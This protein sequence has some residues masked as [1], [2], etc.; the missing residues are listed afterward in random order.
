MRIRL[1]FVSNSS[2]A[3]FLVSLEEFD[4]VIELAGYYVLNIIEH[5]NGEAEYDKADRYKP[6]YKNLLRTSKSDIDQDIPVFIQ[7][8]YNFD[9][10]IVKR[11]DAYYVDTDQQFTFDIKGPP[12]DG[13]N[14]VDEGDYGKFTKSD[15]YYIPEF[16]VIGEIKYI[17]ENSTCGNENH[18]VN[19][20]LQNGNILCPDCNKEELQNFGFSPLLSEEVLKEIDQQWK[21]KFRTQSEYFDWNELYRLFK[22]NGAI[23]VDRESVGHLSLYLEALVKHVTRKGL[24]L[25]NEKKIT[26]E[27][28][29]KALDWVKTI[30]IKY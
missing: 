20:F 1:G 22:D 18:D 15:Y 25:S 23:M 19:Y 30:K 6:I 10:Y 13:L 21:E 4:T 29:E 12:V 7:T 24:E 27:H 2:T 28:V 5:L 8:P 9:T 17:H 11:E 16:D 14:V 26:I 3:S